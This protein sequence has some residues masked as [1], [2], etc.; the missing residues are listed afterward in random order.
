MTFEAARIHFLGD[1]VTPIAVVVAWWPSDRVT[2]R[3][4]MISDFSQ[5]EFFKISFKTI[6]VYCRL[7]S[8]L[9]HFI[10]GYYI[11][12]VILGSKLGHICVNCLKSFT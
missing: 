4:Y 12:D 11:G 6:L 2:N 1:A 10:Y 8:L 3:Y 5:V 7:F 9:G